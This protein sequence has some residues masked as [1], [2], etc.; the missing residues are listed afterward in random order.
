MARYDWTGNKEPPVN[1]SERM[2]H[3]GIGIMNTTLLLLIDWMVDLLIIT[4]RISDEKRAEYISMFE[5]CTFGRQIGMIKS[6]FEN[7]EIR[8]PQ[9]ESA[10]KERNKVIHGYRIYESENLHNDAVR[11]HNLIRQLMDMTLA[12][13]HLHNRAKSQ[14]KKGNKRKNSVKKQII[15]RVFRTNNTDGEMYK[16]RFCE[17]LRSEG[18]DPD[19]EGMDWDSIFMKNGYCVCGTDTVQ[20]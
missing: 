18:I 7:T 2:I 20:R 9:F 3:E 5:S 19:A 4:D 1:V 6:L 12:V 11:I 8:Y 14:K 13:E 15:D 16:S 17:L 10:V